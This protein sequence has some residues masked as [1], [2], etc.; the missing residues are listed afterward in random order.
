MIVQIVG[1]QI[2]DPDTIFHISIW[3]AGLSQRK[4]YTKLNIL[5]E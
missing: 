3:Q 2:D 4:D 5:I 1:T